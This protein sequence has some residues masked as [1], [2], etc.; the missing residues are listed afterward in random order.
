MG[1]GKIGQMMHVNEGKRR[2]ITLLLNYGRT[3]L[4]QAVGTTVTW[5]GK[6]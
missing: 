4:L 6:T 5:G 1:G 3:E 2:K